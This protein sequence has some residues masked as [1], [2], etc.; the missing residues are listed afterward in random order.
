MRYDTRTG[1]RESRYINA[2]GSWSWKD[3][4]GGRPWSALWVSKDEFERRWLRLLGYM[5]KGTNG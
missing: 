5:E 2:D 1:I 3:G 4:Y